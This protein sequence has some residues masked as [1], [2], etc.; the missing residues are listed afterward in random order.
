MKSNPSI[1]ALFGQQRA[2]Y[3]VR[4]IRLSSGLVKWKSAAISRSIAARSLAA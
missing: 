4:S 3:V 2:K 1:D